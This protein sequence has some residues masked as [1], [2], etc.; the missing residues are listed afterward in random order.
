MKYF[1]IVNPNSG[2]VNK[3]KL[4]NNIR[5][6]CI[7]R[8][9]PYEIMYTKKAGDAKGLAKKI[10][11]EECVVFSV[12]GD[13][14]LNEVLNGIVTSEHKILGNIPAGSGNDFD[15]TLKQQQP[16]IISI[17]LGRINRRFFVNVACLGL[18]ADVANN[19]SFIRNKKWIPVS[20]RYNASLI[21]TYF[22]YK[23]KKLKI[24]MGE[25]QVENE[26]TILAIGNG[27]YYGGGFRI[28]P[29]ALL[30]DGML[31]IYFV[32]KMPKPK[33]IPVLMKLLKGNHESSPYVKRYTDK[34]IIVDSEELCIF[35]VD[36][37][38]M[39]SNHFEI[40]I[41]PNTL[42]VLNDRKLTEE[43]VYGND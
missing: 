42:K 8:E 9:I 24:T 11:D 37:E 14:N 2:K 23:F 13:G 36:G 34:K 40:E 19:I 10:P 30:D 39:R 26:C 20:Q 35:N 41:L 27:Q 22:K 4:E 38:M 18:D 5:N 15:K 3:S 6:A 12:G 1:F 17:D 28:A 16:G 21:Y 43:I 25:T 31:D 32:E 7:R 33:M 29:H